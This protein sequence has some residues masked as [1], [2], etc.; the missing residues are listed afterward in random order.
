MT[1]SYYFEFLN[2]EVKSDEQISK[3][4]EYLE[5]YAIQNKNQ[6]YVIDQP[7][8]ERKYKYSYKKAIVLL[9]PKVK[10]L[11]VN[12][13]EDDEEFNNFVDDFIYDLGIISDK[14]DYNE[15]LGRTRNWRDRLIEVVNFNEKPLEEMEE[16]ITFNALTGMENRK[17][18]LLISLLTGSINDINRVEGD[19]PENNLEQIK[20]NIILFDSEQTRFIFQ[21]PNKQ[22]VT[23]QGLA[24]TGKTELLLHKLKDIY[25]NEADSKIFFTCFNKILSKELKN[26]IPDFFDF[27]KVREQIKW[28]E[29]L[30]V[31]RSWGSGADKNS[32]LYSFICHTYD[33]PFER[34]N[35]GTTFENVCRRALAHLE[36]MDNFKPFFDYILIDESQDFNE[37]FFKL[38]EKVTKKQVYVA[39]DIFQ[40]I[41]YSGD[42]ELNKPDYLLNRVYRTDPRTVMMAHIIGFGL[43]ERPVV[44]WLE[45]K[46]WEACGYHIEK[47]NENYK[48]YREP[49]KRF[50]NLPDDNARSIKVGIIPEDRSYLEGV[51]KAIEEIR[52]ENPT[53]EPDDI[54]IVFLEN[55]DSNYKLAER[56]AYQVDSKYGWSSV[57]GYE[58][59]NKKKGAL[60]I[61]N[62]NNVKGLEF[63]FIICVTTASLNKN[64]TIRN[65]L[66]MMLTRSFLTSYLILSSGNGDLNVKLKRAAKELNET[67][68]ITIE[69]PNPDE[70]MDTSALML[71]SNGNKSQY[72]IVEEIL[73]SLG[74]E[75]IARKQQLHTLV[76]V[77]LQNSVDSDT[78]YNLIASNLDFL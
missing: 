63:P 3:V 46:E 70:V 62:R 33:I 12:F 47:S 48:L 75:D 76:N 74:V 40:S 55:T 29:R 10:I 35:W 15:F 58:V 26:R 38:C 25:V 57:K 42:V 50:E 56:I 2:E 28:E 51:L 52:K 65:S 77:M 22:R 43:L 14:Y 60:F 16:V 27:M 31:E 4:L 21:S 37:Y 78:I 69:K 8:G 36:S 49:L 32:G 71:E 34:Y 67:G 44:R 9:I 6:V 13:G 1:S 73:T 7:I 68:T 64:T 61:S 41:F 59:K 53:V 17:A 5:E 19:V 72:E 23:I 39:G 11:I 45:D 20:K 18:E 30:W 24:G 66:Y 54:G